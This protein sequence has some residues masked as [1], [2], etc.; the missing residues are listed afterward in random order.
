V[1]GDPKLVVRS[2]AG[3]RGRA[4]TFL[5]PGVPDRNVTCV[6]GDGGIGK[7]LL[8]LVWIAAVVA[9]GGE[10]LIVVAED[11]ADVAK[12]RLRALGVDLARVHFLALEWGTDENGQPDYDAA[13]VSLP[14][15]RDALDKLVAELGERLR[16][17]VIDP[18][19]ECLDSSV[20]SH[21][22]KSLRR[23]IASLRRIASRRDVAVVV[24]AHLNKSAALSLRK[25]IDGSGALFDGSRSV[26]LLAADPDDDELRV[27]AH[28]K[29]NVSELLDAREYRLEAILVP[30][31]DG[32]PEGKTARLVDA[33]QTSARTVEELL[34]EREG[35]S[36]PSAVEIAESWLRDMLV[37]GEWHDSAGLKTLAVAS[38][39]RKRTL[40]R[41]SRNLA[42]EHERRG[43]PSSTYWR[44]PSH[45]AS[46][47]ET[48][49]ENG[50]G[51]TVEAAQMRMVEPD[52]SDHSRT[53]ASSETGG[54]SAG[55]TA[56]CKHVEQ[57]RDRLGD[58]HCASCEPWHWPSEV[59]ETR[60][61][62]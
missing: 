27:L 17:L 8:T 39:I 10:A 38:G 4:V 49:S 61:V 41:A 60:T 28:G 46:V 24:V 9:A 14:E 16:L 36:E 43:F 33:E 57:W 44:L 45:A 47:A 2:F 11:G 51:A 5:R 35:E 1:N 29:S 18:W 56:L 20:D 55:A 58:W 21:I 22:A 30:A 37:D 52:R 15:Q 13:A 53:R 48:R 3:H 25:R 40:E 62:A 32:E 54:M 26:F 19:A 42:V 59:R 50:A 31:E 34:A 12:L 23:A 6:A 7:S